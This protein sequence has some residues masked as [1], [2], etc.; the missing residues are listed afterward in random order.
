[1]SQYSTSV[2]RQ[3]SPGL[4]AQVCPLLRL[5]SWHGLVY[6]HAYI[7]HTWRTALL[8]SG[9]MRHAWHAAHKCAAA[10]VR[11]S[12]A[13]PPVAPGGVRRQAGKP[14]CLRDGTGGPLY[15]GKNPCK[16]GLFFGPE[17]RMP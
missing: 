13:R 6:D 4:P 3:N 7:V 12:V 2:V 14:R 5:P 1:M 17:T 15:R 10:R 11:E 8:R 9:A 16:G